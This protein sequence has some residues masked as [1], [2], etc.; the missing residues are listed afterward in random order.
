M[1]GILHLGLG[2]GLTQRP[3][4][5]VL[6]LLVRV[7]CRLSGCTQVL[8]KGSPFPPGLVPFVTCL[9]PTLPS[10]EHFL[11]LTLSCRFP[12]RK[13]SGVIVDLTVLSNSNG[14]CRLHLLF[15][16][17]EGAKMPDLKRVQVFR[18]M[19]IIKSYP[20]HRI[21]KIE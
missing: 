4:W 7:P 19:G 8:R 18:K 9:Y 12:L 15:T 2:T 5:I 10:W 6:S 14:T 3:L 16:G 21:V 17:N 13:S 20:P 1:Q 11:Y